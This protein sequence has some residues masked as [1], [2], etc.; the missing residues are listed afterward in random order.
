MRSSHR[1]VF[2]GCSTLHASAAVNCDTRRMKALMAV[3]QR[4]CGLE[5][6]TAGGTASG[7]ILDSA[8]MMILRTCRPTLQ[9]PLLEVSGPVE[10]PRRPNAPED[11]SRGRPPGRGA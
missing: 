6:D 3:T 5:T 7:L 8:K 4:K 9:V 11:G 2:H 1:S 10:P